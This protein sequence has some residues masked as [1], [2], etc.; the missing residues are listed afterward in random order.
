MLLR[1]LSRSMAGGSTRSSRIQRR[2]NI[3]TSAAQRPSTPPSLP[4]AA[5]APP[6]PAADGAADPSL[7][8]L[9]AQIA[10]K[11]FTCTQCGKCCTGRGDVW[12]TEEEVA[13]I[14]AR[15][16]RPISAFTKSYSRARGFRLLRDRPGDRR[17][18]ACIFL[19]PDDKTC[20]IHD[21]RPKQCS[22][23]P[24]WP[25]LMA[26]EEWRAEAE[27]VCE[28]FDHPDAPETDELD[29]AAPL[30]E[31]TK[32]EA[33]R[34]ASYGRGG[35]S[36]RRGGGRE[37]EDDGGGWGIGARKAS[38]M[39]VGG[40][41]GGAAAEAASA[42]ASASGAGSSTPTAPRS[43]R[44]RKRGEKAALYDRLM[45]LLDRAEGGD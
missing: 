23:Y 22:L 29:A 24:W 11:R 18:E 10:D 42:S 19:G 30:R 1:G 5:G 27:A 15:T 13:A 44:E 17:L 45:G 4:S 38:D 31:A 12:V 35:K 40:G 14:S 36:R 37:D 26:P 7:A 32:L 6:P 21:V 41:G 9:I 43:K 16:R 39:P 33:M 8:P 25:G 2:H 3:S 34:L 28:G 20:T